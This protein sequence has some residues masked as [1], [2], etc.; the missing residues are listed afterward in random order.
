MITG[1]MWWPGVILTERR[2]EG[3]GGDICG[4]HTSSEQCQPGV[5]KRGGGR[6]FHRVWVSGWPAWNSP[7]GSPDKVGSRSQGW[8]DGGRGEWDRLGQRTVIA[9]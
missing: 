9:R 4:C 5:D 2:G 6:E 3:D 8:T 1:R 7:V